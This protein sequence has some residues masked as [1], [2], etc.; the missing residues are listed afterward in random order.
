MGHLLRPSLLIVGASLLCTGAASAD[1]VAGDAN[2][3]P[4]AL[5]AGPHALCEVTV[6][7][8]SN[9]EGP[10]EV[11]HL[12]NFDVDR[13]QLGNDAISSLKVSPGCTATLYEHAG[14]QGQ[15]RSVVGDVR[16]VGD[17]WNDLVSSLRVQRTPNANAC[18]LTLFRDAWYEG[19]TQTLVG[20]GNYDMDRL[21]I[22]N[23]TVSSFK[24]TGGCTVTLYEHAGFQ[25]EAR[26][27]RADVDWVGDAWNDRVS[28]IRIQ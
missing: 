4:G 19:P 16:W 14:F 2:T 23:D 5:A 24:I 25:G 17:D 26:A 3:R 27:E 18:T 11:F 20:V 12:G 9:Y 22:G 7:R 10:S 6:Y 15:S 13:F 1:P 28:S 8:D 21:S